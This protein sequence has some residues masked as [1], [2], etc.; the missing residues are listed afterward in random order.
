MNRGL[1]TEEHI[2]T[3]RPAALLKETGGV[4]ILQL[5]LIIALVQADRFV[6]LGGNLSL[7]VGAVFIL[8]PVAVLDRTGRPYDR[9]GFSWGRPLIDFLWVLGAAVILFPPIAFFSPT[10][11]GLRDAQFHFVLPSGYPTA[12]FAHLLVTAL[13]E[14][15]FYRGYLMGRLDDIFTKRKK[16]LG[17]ELGLGW[18][19]QAVLFAAGHFLV[20]FNP[21]RL[22]VFFPALAFGWLKAGRGTLVAPVLFHAASNI[23]M[24]IFRAGLGL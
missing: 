1:R 21:G 4:F 20:D 3:P 13:P 18:I 8:L 19:I 2:T 7:L 11:W 10:V 14:E 6:G 24:D 15:V 5:I 12:I 9:Y 16:V 17:V 23:F 22:A